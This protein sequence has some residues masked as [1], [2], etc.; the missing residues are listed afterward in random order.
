MPSCK[1]LSP[2]SLTL[3][4]AQE[5]ETKK[6]TLTDIA[7]EL[8]DVVIRYLYSGGKYHWPSVWFAG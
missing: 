2:F 1:I 4:D 3:S 7:P 6:I 5:A 8:V